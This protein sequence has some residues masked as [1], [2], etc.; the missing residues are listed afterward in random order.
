M[1]WVAFPPGSPSK[2]GSFV[3]SNKIELNRIKKRLTFF[4]IASLKSFA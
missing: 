2:P 1:S 3:L 4:K